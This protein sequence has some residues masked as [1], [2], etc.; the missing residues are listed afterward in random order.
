MTPTATSTLSSIS[1]PTP[2]PDATATPTFVKLSIDEPLF[3]GVK[4]V[5]GN[6]IPGAL[7]VV[8]DLDDVRI[9]ATGNVNSEGRYEIDLTSALGAF[10]LSGLETGHRIQAESERQIY[11]AIV[12]SPIAVQ[13]QV[14]LPFVS[15][16]S[17][18]NPGDGDQPPPP[19]RRP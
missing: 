18:S 7:V 16:S 3:A 17:L 14:F 15:K 11:Q 13:V 2:T 6:G 1:T 12:Q 8:R 10:Q 19:P 9:V 5:K 4:V